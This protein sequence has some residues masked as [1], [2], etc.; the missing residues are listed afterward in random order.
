VKNPPLV[1]LVSCRSSKVITVLGLA[2]PLTRRSPA[3]M[4]ASS[5]RICA[6]AGAVPAAR[7][8]RANP[9]GFMPPSQGSR[10]NW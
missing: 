8:T 7:H 3:T 10:E 5:M 4:R 6:R 9:I 2:R 1:L